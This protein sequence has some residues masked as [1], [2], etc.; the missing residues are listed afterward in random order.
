[1]PRHGDSHTVTIRGQF[2]RLALFPV[3]W[4]GGLFLIYLLIQG[5]NT[6]WEVQEVNG[7]RE[8]VE[9][10][11]LPFLP[12][13]LDAPV[14]DSNPFR[15]FLIFAAPLFAVCA[16]WI[17]IT[18]RKSINFLIS[19]V[20]INCAALTLL[21]FIHIRKSAKLILW[22]FDPQRDMFLST[23]PFHWQ[24]AAY[25]TVALAGIL[26]LGLYHYLNALKTFRRSSPSGLYEFI[27]V[28]LGLLIIFSQ[29]TL[30]AACVGVMI[31]VFVCQL[32]YRHLGY[33]APLSRKAYLIAVS[34]A[35]VI[36][37]G[38]FA[39]HLAVKLGQKTDDEHLAAAI[40]P[41]GSWSATAAVGGEMLREHP[42]TGWGAGTFPFVYQEIG[43]KNGI[44][45]LP[46]TLDKER[47]VGEIIRI[48]AEV[49]IIGSILLL[50]SFLYLFKFYLHRRAFLNPI[51]GFLLLGTLAGAVLSI[52][53]PTF[54]SGAFLGTWTLF[55]TFGAIIVRVENAVKARNEQQSS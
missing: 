25:F 26:G 2:R 19:L 28:I 12:A 27:A 45:S 21:G 30:A 29:S 46:S 18:R 15:W 3:F 39:Q 23:F 31:A 24:G 36:I 37:G 47:A 17:G 52:L 44:A 41:A 49:G 5:F 33:E 55:L 1:M 40:A 35:L 9:S 43:E 20:A 53:S 10:S 8:V 48:P 34:V 54:S 42:L 6:G 4:F 11:H 32:G 14:T 7:V 38:F 16:A 13:G 51:V 50:L 22:F